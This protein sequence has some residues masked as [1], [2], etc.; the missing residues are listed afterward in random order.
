MTHLLRFL[1]LSVPNSQIEFISSPLLFGVLLISSP[2]YYRNWCVLLFSSFVSTSTYVETICSVALFFFYTIIVV[3]I[4]I[5]NLIGSVIQQPWLF[6]QI[7]KGC[8]SSCFLLG[9][10]NFETRLLLL[11]SW[12]LLVWLALLFNSLDF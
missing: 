4:T 8:I 6:F 2:A 9:M 10:K 5:V 1:T 3:V 11:L 7:S 12:L